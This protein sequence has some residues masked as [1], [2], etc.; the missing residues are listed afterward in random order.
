MN[1]LRSLL[2]QRKGLA[3]RILIAEVLFIALFWCGNVDYKNIYSGT[4][5]AQYRKMAQCAPSF[6]S[7][8]PAPFA[9]RIGVPWM[10]SALSPGDDAAGFKLI[11]LVLVLALCIQFF[12]VLKLYGTHES[13]ALVLTSI[14]LWNPYL[15]EFLLFNPFQA[16]DTCAYLL[17]LIALEGFKRNS[18]AVFAIA[19]LLGAGVRETPM[20]I[21]PALLLAERSPIKKRLLFLAAAMP[22]LAMY[23][24]IRSIVPVG[25]PEW[26]LLSTLVLYT[27]EVASVERWGRLALNTCAP[28]SL[29]FG[30]FAWRQRTTRWFVTEESYL[31][32]AIVA[33]SFLGGDVE[34]LA[35]PATL[36]LLIMFRSSLEQCLEYA[37]FR[38]LLAIGI[39]FC[40]LH[41]LYA[42]YT[43][44]PKMVYYG[45]AVFFCGM[46]LWTGLRATRNRTTELAT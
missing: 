4:D 32:A 11:Q 45:G 12:R 34:R 9:Y 42:R 20:L 22:S 28:L 36:L 26:S 6:D 39:V 31:A 37:P 10:V 27:P 41:F 46:I 5:L 38:Y 25:N 19:L 23:V 16:G 18:V 15:G 24:F 44:L 2:D 21:V 33:C 3:L 8:I 1:A 35:A 13:T 7:T 43:I 29:L 40:S 30:A 14:A 17:M